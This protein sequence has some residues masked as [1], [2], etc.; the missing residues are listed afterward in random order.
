M[1]FID[2]RNDI[3]DLFDYCAMGGNIHEEQKGIFSIHSTNTTYINEFQKRLCWKI[4]Q[5]QI[6]QCNQSILSE[7]NINFKN[8]SNTNEFITSYLNLFTEN[9]N[10]LNKQ[11]YYSEPN[12]DPK[13]C[14]R[15]IEIIFNQL[16]KPKPLYSYLNFHKTKHSTRKSI[17]VYVASWNTGATDLKYTSWFPD[18]NAWL[19]PKGNN[20]NLKPDLYLI[21]LQEAVALSTMNLISTNK[22]TQN[23]ID[24]WESTIVETISTAGNGKYVKI[25]SMILVGLVLMVCVREDNEKYIDANTI[26]AKYIKTGLGGT[27]G[28]KGSCLI[29][30]NYKN[31]SFSVCCSHLAAGVQKNLNRINEINFVLNSRFEQSD[32]VSLNNNTNTINTATTTNTNTNEQSISNTF[33]QSLTN[34]TM[35]TS[36]INSIYHDDDNTSLSINHNLLTS[37]PSPLFTDSDIWFIF[38]DLNFRNDTDI[39]T[40]KTH[41]DNED[42]KQLLEYDQLYKS[43]AVLSN[44]KDHID[45]SEIKFPPTYKYI[46]GSNEYD[47]SKTKFLSSWCDRI[48]FNLDKKEQKDI[49][50]IEYDRVLNGFGCS[51]HRPIYGIFECWIYEDIPEIKEKYE[52]EIKMNIE[53]GISSEYLKKKKQ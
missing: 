3:I 41:I 10:E 23:K 9:L 33:M 51:D 35:I 30:F 1:N 11:Y 29:T 26:K 52:N 21:G 22:E 18:L 15:I 19:I 28:N 14:Q 34:S 2:K 27:A 20:A 31:T 24:A 12:T 17:T 44:L 53:M 7:C 6:S 32:L 38:G 43:K 48:L 50:C 39:E 4:I 45:E 40:I 42:Y 8:P 25:K 36:I 16:H 37:K 46:L 47:T 49:K 13:Q 5:K